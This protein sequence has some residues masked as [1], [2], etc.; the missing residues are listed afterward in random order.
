ME[1]SAKKG[2]QRRRK[3]PKAKNQWH[4]GGKRKFTDEREP[5][6]DFVQSTAPYVQRHCEYSARDVDVF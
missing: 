6:E 3:G 4:T 1:G 5:E 2:Q